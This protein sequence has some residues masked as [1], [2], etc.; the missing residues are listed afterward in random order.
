MLK[1]TCLAICSLVI[2][3]ASVSIT[4]PQGQSPVPQLGRNSVKEVVAALT[5]EEKVKLL[6]GMGFNVDLPGLQ[7][8]EESRSTPERVAGAAGRTYPIPR[9]GIPSLTLSDG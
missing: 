1:N 2:V 9:L 7:R 8:T 6:V 3:L 4:A 5:L